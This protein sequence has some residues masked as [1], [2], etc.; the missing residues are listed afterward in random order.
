MEDGTRTKDEDHEN[1]IKLMETGWIFIRGV[2][3]AIELAKG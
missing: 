1:E 3:M 2:E